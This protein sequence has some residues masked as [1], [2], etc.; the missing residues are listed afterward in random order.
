MKYF[1]F[2]F[3][4][5]IGCFPIVLWFGIVGFGISTAFVCLFIDTSK[6]FNS[7]NGTVLLQDNKK[8]CLEH[9]MPFVV[10]FIITLGCFITGIVM[11]CTLHNPM[12]VQV[13]RSHGYHNDFVYHVQKPEKG[14]DKTETKTDVATVQQQD[15]PNRLAVP[16][17]TVNHVQIVT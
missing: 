5:Q 14:S 9:L 3:S 11:G 10:L 15:N 4:F 12:N 2:L 6:V 1:L 16:K 17:L 7:C 8:P 13:R